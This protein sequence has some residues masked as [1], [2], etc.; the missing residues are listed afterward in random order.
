M[1]GKKH[2]YGL[3]IDFSVLNW[4]IISWRSRLLAC[5]LLIRNLSASF[6]ALGKSLLVLAN[7]KTSD[8]KLISWS[9][10]SQT[11]P[12]LYLHESNRPSWAMSIL[13][14]NSFLNSFFASSSISFGVYNNDINYRY[15][16][17]WIL[18]SFLI[19]NA[20]IPKL[21]ET[22]SDVFDKCLRFSLIK[23]E[24]VK[25]KLHL[26]LSSLLYILYY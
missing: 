1:I 5:D 7:W 16:L 20:C 9:K 25:A 8:T 13:Q 24:S 14:M 23:V 6:V 11:F 19:L 21:L 10:P 15:I 12:T 2:L 3:E 18:F 22:L 26:V 17:Q 4:C